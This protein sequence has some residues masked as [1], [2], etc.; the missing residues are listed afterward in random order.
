MVRRHGWQL[1]AHTFQVVAITVFFLLVVAFYAFFAP[2]L[3][4][5]VLEYAAMAV[6][7]T[8]AL[9]VFLL[10]V[11]CT[12]I[13]PADP[14]ILS[15]FGHTSFS[16]DKTKQG[17]SPSPLVINLGQG[18]A[19][20]SPAF[21]SNIG[22]P[23]TIQSE[24]KVPSEAG[25]MKLAGAG[26]SGKKNSEVC[27]L[28]VVG[29]L[30]CGWLFR[31]DSCQ[32]E[33]VQQQHVIEEDALFCTLCNAEVRKFSKHCR[34]CD[35][36]VDGFDHHCRWLNNCVGKKNYVTF[37][38]LMA[39]SLTWL[40][41]EWGIG[42]AVLVR[43]F[44][45]KR[46]T[47]NHI[48]EKLGDVFSLA[49][50]AAI[51][52]LCTTVALVASIPL[53]ELFF[54][55]IILIR[56]G[57]TTYEYVVAMRSQNEPTAIS[58]E[59]EPQSIPSSPTSSTATGLSGASSH[60]LHYKGAWCTPPRIFVDQDE[61]IPHLGP[62]QVPSTVD[63]DDV[64]VVNRAA[65]RT[66]KHPVRISA[67]KLAKLKPD[68]AMRAGAKAR[69][70][71]SILRPIGPRGVTDADYCSSGNAS[72]RSSMSVDLAA[73]KDSRN[74]RI[75]SPLKYSYPPS[76]ASKDDIETATQSMSSYS[77]PS[78]I[79]ELATLSSLS[80]EHRYGAASG[81]HP[82]ISGSQIHG[83]PLPTIS[84]NM[85][86]ARDTLP[87][88]NS[89]PEHSIYLGKTSGSDVYGTSTF[90][91]MDDGLAR[92]NIMGQENT[93]QLTRVV[94]GN[95]R[96]SVF[97]DQGAGR[98]VSFPVS[99]R[100]ERVPEIGPSFLTQG[101]GLVGTS[102]SPFSE[103]RFME[104]NNDRTFSSPNPHGLE[105]PSSNVHTFHSPT[106]RPIPNPNSSSVQSSGAEPENLL[107]T[108]E[109]IFYG[110]PLSVPFVEKH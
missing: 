101:Q 109:S 39:T 85:F 93:N 98:Y 33:G 70:S 75:Q 88:Y 44:I 99:G 19:K 60:G 96:S 87:I 80:Q 14:G 17:L 106:S 68:E 50:Y 43:C 57:I 24:K 105:S 72:S 61:I 54:F 20:Q 34:S 78:H 79:N 71:S 58:A 42:I 21:S 67:W 49:P 38:S 3:G 86:N 8:M 83:E 65:N 7:T 46:G 81:V 16:P 28:S 27:F 100:N 30:L 63:P 29:C 5:D 89:A 69:E 94:R 13:D 6:Y 36:C 53:G 92:H 77:S 97:W 1:P 41:L 62:G 18:G 95:H 40:V 90:D 64:A 76:R 108:G 12:A 102:M 35:K 74:K 73:K 11:R 47:E 25:N 45:D 37:V 26:D 22:S 15:N 23:L 10:Y 84:T 4:N 103:K 104:G 66:Q 9:A 48:I 51:V 91:R 31:D 59:G 107:Y 55:H 52:I 32:N 56:K 2:F 82:T 110:G